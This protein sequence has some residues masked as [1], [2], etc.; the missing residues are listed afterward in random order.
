[1]SHL[2]PPV[3]LIWTILTALLG[4]FFASHLWAFDRFQCL[5]WNQGSQG[6]FKRVMTYSYLLALPLFFV[7][8]IVSTIIKYD[9]G[10]IDIPG[11]GIVAKPYTV[12]TPGHR[13]AILPLNFCFAFASSFEIISHLE[14]NCFW[15]YVVTSGPA[16]KEWFKSIYFKIWAC[17]SVLAFFYPPLVTLLTRDDVLRNEA[18]T[19]L[20]S[21]IAITLNT[22]TFLPV[23]WKFP[24][25]LYGLRK[26]NV[27][28][29][30]IVRLTKFHEMN[31]IRVFFRTLVGVPILILACDG[32]S[33]RHIAENNFGTDFLAIVA[34]V[35]IVVSSGITL[36]IFFPRSI[37]GEITRQVARNRGIFS[38][39]TKEAQITFISHEQEQELYRDESLL[40]KDNISLSDMSHNQGN[41]WRNS[42]SL[43]LSKQASLEEGVAPPVQLPASPY[44]S[45][46]L[47][48]NRRMPET[49]PEIEDLAR[50]EQGQA[51]SWTRYTPK[52]PRI[53]HFVH[54]F[55]SPI[56][57]RRADGA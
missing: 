49:I 51:T 25:F 24:R 37:E 4:A 41:L 11:Y 1:M 27:D 39:D 28:M 13:A 23:L 38:K 15:Q 22:I 35:G 16:Q 36:T 8:S 47:Q 31:K 54:N 32:L 56:D 48:P 5:R 2:N 34:G 18:S 29:E 7:Y 44:P 50:V 42:D 57:F 21:G 43:L 17:G 40:P 6:A 26:D 33:H 19:F 10:Y 3:L 9:E 55:R 52:K 53:S 20:A 14:E 45:N 12:W 46:G 30:T